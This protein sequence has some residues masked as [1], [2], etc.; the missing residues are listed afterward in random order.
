MR[1]RSR[2]SRSIYATVPAADVN[3]ALEAQ[4]ACL[5]GV[6]D[7]QAQWDQERGAIEQEVQR[8][9]SNPTYKFV[10]RMNDCD[11]CRHAVRA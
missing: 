3:V 4:A 11:V 8:D 5:R 2:T 1:T 10:D 9:L 7:S 6:D